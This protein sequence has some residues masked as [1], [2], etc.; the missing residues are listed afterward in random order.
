VVGEKLKSQIVVNVV[1]ANIPRC[2]SH[3]LNHLQPLDVGADIRP[4]DKACIFII[5]QMSYL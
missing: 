2:A 3:R 5:G 1:V 4:P